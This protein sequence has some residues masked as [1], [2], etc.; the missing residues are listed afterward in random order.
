MHG[1][2]KRI[3]LIVVVF[4]VLLCNARIINA[5]SKKPVMVLAGS[6]TIRRWK[7][8]K[9]IFNDYKVINTALGGSTVTQW[10]NL[11]K[12]RI[13]DHKPDVLVFY[14][15][16]NDMQD[17]NPETGAV[18]GMDNAQNTIRLLSLIR[19]KCKNTKIIYIGIN[20]CNRNPHIWDQIDISN[21]IM[22]NTCNRDKNMY[23]IDIIDKLLINNIPDDRLFE[24]D[25]LHLNKSGYKV[26]NKYIGK[27]IKNILK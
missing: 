16:A 12:D 9:K 4:V 1:T 20:H 18:N 22:K 2:I 11:Y 19:T 10:F 27:F 14:C 21:N 13:I 23:Y 7:S 17:G 25:Q 26:W 8:A 24:Y 3:I 15:G 6:S 5:K